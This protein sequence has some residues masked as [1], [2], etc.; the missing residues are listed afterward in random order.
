MSIEGISK[1][2]LVEAPPSAQTMREAAR[3]LAEMDPGYRGFA[4]NRQSATFGEILEAQE[5]SCGTNAPPSS[6]VDHPIISS[7]GNSDRSITFD[8]LSSMLRQ[9][10]FLERAL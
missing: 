8:D 3:L 6:D 4:Y 9:A 1:S 5:T 7:D 2:A 10:E